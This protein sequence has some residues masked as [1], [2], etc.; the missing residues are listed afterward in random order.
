MLNAETREKLTG[1][2]AKHSSGARRPGPGPPGEYILDQAV[3]VGGKNHRPEPTL[4][5]LPETG[6]WLQ[7]GPLSGTGRW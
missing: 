3:L 7:D 6:P 5:L 4:S 1:R 2:L